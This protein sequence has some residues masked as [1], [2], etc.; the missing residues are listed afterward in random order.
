MGKSSLQ[1]VNEADKSKPRVQ[2]YKILT[3]VPITRPTVQES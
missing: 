2:Q 1:Y 3:D